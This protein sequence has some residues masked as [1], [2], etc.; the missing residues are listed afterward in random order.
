MYAVTKNKILYM[1]EPQPLFPWQQR[2]GKPIGLVSG[3]LYQFDGFYQDQADIDASALPAGVTRP[4]FLKY[5]D[6]DGDGIININDKVVGGLPNLP[7]TTFGLNLGFSYKGI[8]LNALFQGAKDYNFRME[9]GAIDAFRANLQPVHLERWQPGDGN[10]ARYPS[11]TYTTTTVNSSEAFPSDFWN[12]DAYYIRLRSL[13]LAYNL[14]LGIINKMGLEGMRI[15]AN[16]ANLFTWSNVTKL[17]TF[18][19]ETQS[20]TGGTGGLYPQQKII[21]FGLTVSFK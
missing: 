9:A 2:T 1:D 15:Y 13:E 6:I 8:S 14:P 17:Y 11:L 16:G 5:K 19:P 12:L 4:G 3:G 18:D 7:Q 10:T 20:G 21:N